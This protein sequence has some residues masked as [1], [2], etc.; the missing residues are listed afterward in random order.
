[1]DRLDE[2]KALIKQE[3]SLCDVKRTP[4]V[5]SLNNEKNYSELEEMIIERVKDGATIGEAITAIE[6][7]FNINYLND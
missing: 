3:L 6:R 4:T 2:L 5:C 1:M 7:N